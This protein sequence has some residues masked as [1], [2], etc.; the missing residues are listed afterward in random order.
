MGNTF[1]WTLENLDLKQQAARS[2]SA[3]FVISRRSSSRLFIQKREKGEEAER[4]KR[5]G[6]KGIVVAGKH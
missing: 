6:D 5:L 4:G 3:N 2:Y 1:L